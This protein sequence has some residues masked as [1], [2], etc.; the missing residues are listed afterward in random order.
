MPD[1][2]AAARGLPLKVTRGTVQETSYAYDAPGN[3]TQRVDATGTAAFT[4]DNGNRLATATD[5]VTAR[6]LTYG[7]DNAS[8]LKTITATS[9]TASTQT[10]DYDNMN[11]VTGQT[12]KNGSGTQLAKITFGG[13]RTTTSPPRPRRA[14][15]A[16]AP[17]PMTTTTPD[18]SPPGPP[19][20]A[21]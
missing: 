2:V 14:R 1:R 7:Y 13:T 3:P 5:P 6:T 8:R 20:A 12:L 18:A 4:W 11:R 17:T 19:P 10:I 15:P 21:P 16:R 9:G